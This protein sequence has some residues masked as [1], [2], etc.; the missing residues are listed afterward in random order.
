LR[1]LNLKEIKAFRRSSKLTRDLVDSNFPCSET[2][3]PA[4]R[5]DIH[6]TEKLMDYRT[7]LEKGDIPTTIGVNS[8]YHFLPFTTGKALTLTLDPPCATLISFQNPSQ[9]LHFQHLRIPKSNIFHDYTLVDVDGTVRMLLCIDS[10]LY[11]LNPERLGTEIETICY[12]PWADAINFTRDGYL[13]GISFNGLSELW[14]SNISKNNIP[15]RYRLPFPILGSF[16]DCKTNQ[17][18]VLTS[19]GISILELKNKSISTRNFY[20]DFLPQPTLLPVI[21]VRGSITKGRNFLL[22]GYYHDLYY[23]PYYCDTLDINN[24]KSFNF[25][26]NI[27]SLKLDP[28][29]QFVM[30]S[31]KNDRFPLLIDF[32]TGERA[33][34][35]NSY[36]E[37]LMMWR[38]ENFILSPIVEQGKVHLRYTRAPTESKKVGQ[39]LKN[40]FEQSLCPSKDISWEN[41]LF[42]SAEWKTKLTEVSLEK[43]SQLYPNVQKLI[44]FIAPAFTSI[45][46]LTR[47]P[48]PEKFLKLAVE[49]ATNRIYLMDYVD[50]FQKATLHPYKNPNSAVPVLTKLINDCEKNYEKEIAKTVLCHLYHPT[51]HTRVN[52]IGI[53]VPSAKTALISHVTERC[54]EI[55]NKEWTAVEEGKRILSELSSWK[56]NI[57]KKIPFIQ[58]DVPILENLLSELSGKVRTAIE[59]KIS[60]CQPVWDAFHN[61][62][63][64]KWSSITIP[65]Q[66]SIV[67]AN[68][69]RAM[70]NSQNLPQA[71]ITPESVL[72]EVLN[73]RIFVQDMHQYVCDSPKVTE[74]ILYVREIMQ[75]STWVPF[76]QWVTEQYQNGTLDEIDR[77]ISLWIEYTGHF[78][79]VGFND[80]TLFQTELGIVREISE[81]M[82]NC[83]LLLGVNSWTELQET[84]FKLKRLIYSMEGT[85]K[86]ADRLKSF[87]EK[88]ALSQIV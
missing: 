42:F 83:Y 65:S 62:P 37:E 31:L 47:H 51:M 43:C 57:F 18:F 64:N 6:I 11:R 55:K 9:P 23:I 61:L 16:F 66:A 80:A 4:P 76:Q 86:N 50:K 49:F 82:Q 26:S 32:S 67:E 10:V 74:Q 77:N 71:K 29:S 75:K 2:F 30:I 22:I 40:L 69:I 73:F 1:S 20:F 60:I 12:L 19:K 8:K 17:H 21:S 24:R 45:S 70:Q 68:F 79:A 87:F 52:Q 88:V 54:T 38:T 28:T 5:Y 36:S 27:S 59:K 84:Q 7:P 53:F 15:E 44:S 39:E 34:I 48:S 13:I 56:E 58:S 25:S 41:S 46:V 81:Q 33:F 35:G 14:R 85:T 78:S 3:R 72:E 63:P